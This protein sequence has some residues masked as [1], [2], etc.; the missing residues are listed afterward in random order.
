MTRRR[1]RNKEDDKITNDNRGWH[2][3]SKRHALA[4]KGI[5]TKRDITN[6]EYKKLYPKSHW[7]L[8]SDHDGVKNKDDCYPFDKD[9]QHT[10]L[11]KEQNFQELDGIVFYDISDNHFIQL[12]NVDDKYAYFGPGSEFYN[13]AKHPPYDIQ[14]KY[15]YDRDKAM[16][17]GGASLLS[18]DARTEE[19][20]IDP[21]S[22]YHE[23]T[24]PIEEFKDL[25]MSDK[26]IAVDIGG[27]ASD[28]HKVPGVL[29]TEEG[30]VVRSPWRKNMEPKEIIEKNDPYYIEESNVHKRK[31]IPIVESEYYD[32]YIKKPE[33]VELSSKQRLK[34]DSAKE[35][36][37]KL[38]DKYM[39]ELLISTDS[40]SE[41]NE[42]MNL[43]KN[44]Y[45][46]RFSDFA[47]V[48]GDGLYEVYGIKGDIK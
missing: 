23:Y 8:D 14:R 32:N 9:R 7:E 30:Y 40:K 45:A 16:E 12:R 19:F 25:V 3:E 13:D 24:I 20:H 29:F 42:T 33:Y 27:E 36:V 22:G 48:E 41:A 1:K 28:I 2:N 44:R 5:K 18:D 10:G 21:R 31:D 26:L 34:G 11:K 46:N 37:K 6:T 17:L 35:I 39:S 43:V 38:Q 15:R 4:S 47:L